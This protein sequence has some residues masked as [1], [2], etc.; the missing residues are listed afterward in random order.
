MF[1]GITSN[2]LSEVVIDIDKNTFMRQSAIV[3]KLSKPIQKS[4]V[5]YK[6]MIA[7]STDLLFI[8]SNKITMIFGVFLVIFNP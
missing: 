5:R 8:I 4:F 1:V 7:F 3:R 2:F 6:N